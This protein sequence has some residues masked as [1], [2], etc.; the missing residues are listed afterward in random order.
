MTHVGDLENRL[1]QAMDQLTVANTQN[2]IL[3]QECEMTRTGLAE[4]QERHG[5]E[6][7]TLKE[8]LERTEQQHRRN[9]TDA[10]TE[11][12]KLFEERNN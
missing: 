11:Q 12:L 8:L 3:Q 2:G 7:D 9:R 4:A 5:R 10:D 6:S 1:R